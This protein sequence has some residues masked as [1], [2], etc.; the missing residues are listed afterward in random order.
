VAYLR[1]SGTGN[2]LTIRVNE[3]K[4]INRELRAGNGTISLRAELHAGQNRIEIQSREAA[5]I[6]CLT[7]RQGEMREISGSH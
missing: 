7:V 6:D 4:P 1:N 5:A 2:L 3:S